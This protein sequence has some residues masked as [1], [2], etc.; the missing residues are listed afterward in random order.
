M[1]ALTESDVIRALHARYGQTAGNGRRYAVAGGVRSHAGFDA[2]RTADFIAM[3]LWPSKGLEIHGH[4]VK[5]SRSDWL[6]E[7]AE[8]EKAAEF[9][10]YV[11]RWWLVVSDPA[12]IRAGELPDGWGLLEMRGERLAARV[13]ASR[14]D[15][16]PMPPTR[17]A[18]LLR[19]VA[20]TAENRALHEHEQLF[21]L[22]TEAIPG[23]HTA[24][25]HQ[26]AAS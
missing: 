19:A 5:V 15:A 17:L 10:P 16:R 8:P 6:R 7:L 26:E 24:T 4:E 1:T 12:I 23:Q 18:A 9:M 20:Q 25:A 13:K 22:R 14:L 21:H 2:R 3:D 11:N